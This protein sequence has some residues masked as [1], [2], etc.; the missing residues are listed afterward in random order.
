MKHESKE[1]RKYIRLGTIFPVE[2]QFIDDQSKPISRVF[3]GFTRNAA[4][5]GMCI[6]SRTEKGKQGLIFIP[7]KTKLK[8]IINI[9]SSA[10][11][12]ESIAVVRW[13]DKTSEYALDEYIFGVQYDEIESDNQKMIERHVRWLYRKPKLVLLFVAILVLFTIALTFYAIQPR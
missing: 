3:Q 11:A 1:K 2:F 7:G 8:L 4:K 9:P 10:L 6:E 5:G 12:T 13:V